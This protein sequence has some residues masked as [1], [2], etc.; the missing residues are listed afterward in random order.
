VKELPEPATM[1]GNSVVQLL[2]RLKPLLVLPLELVQECYEKVKR[3]KPTEQSRSDAHINIAG[4]PRH[5]LAFYDVSLSE[6]LAILSGYKAMPSGQSIVDYLTGLFSFEKGTRLIILDIL[7]VLCIFSKGPLEHKCGLLFDWYTND[8]DGTGS[9]IGTGTETR[10][11][12]GPGTRTSAG[13]GGLMEEGEHAML[14]CRVMACLRK[15]HLAQALDTTEDDAKHIALEA[16]RAEDKEGD[17][18]P[19]IRFKPGLYK[20]DFFQWVQTSAECRAFFSIIEVWNRLV[21]TVHLLGNRTQ[22]VRV[23]MEVG[24]RSAV[25][26]LL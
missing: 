25:H 5:F 22:A 24:L 2:D 4:T 18:H 12:S 17:D 23:L 19:G 14:I 16:R 13:A 1:S 10:G 15:L 7:T 8:N 6:A 9:R 21:D 3:A 26:F 11:G 20:H